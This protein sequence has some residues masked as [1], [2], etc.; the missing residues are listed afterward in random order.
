MAYHFLPPLHEES[1]SAL[2]YKTT[3]SGLAQPHPNFYIQYYISIEYYIIVYYTS[4][5]L[6]LWLKAIMYKTS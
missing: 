6:L 2:L 3:W 4:T 5:F 1:L